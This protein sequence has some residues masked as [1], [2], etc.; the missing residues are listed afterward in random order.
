MT[1]AKLNF[2]EGMQPIR[3]LH[4]LHSMNRGGAENALMNYYRNLNRDLVQFDFLLTSFG[5]S[6]FE[7][8]I[9]DLGGIIYHIPALT[10]RN[11]L[12]YL[13]GLHSFLRSHPEY[14]IVHSHTSS[15]SVIP[16]AI[17]KMNEIPI[18]ISHSHNT[19]SEPGIK[20]RL[21]EALIPL[22]K[23]T[24]NTYFSCGE[25]AAYWLYGKEFYR[26]GKVE[27]I[28]NVINADW[29]KYNTV[30]RAK[31]RKELQCNQATIVIGQVARFNPEKNHK[32]SLE[33]LKEVIKL[34]PDT[35]L[36]L[37]GDGH[38]RTEIEDYAKEL[39]VRSHLKLVGVI[40]NVY[41]YE[42]AMDAFILP[43]LYEGLPLS[44]VEAQVSG[45]PCFTTKG[46]VSTECSVT[47]LVTYLP[48]EAGAKVWAKAIIESTSKIRRDRFE[49]IKEAG[50]DAN[51]SAH[52]LQNRYIELYKTQ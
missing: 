12:P 13:K 48:L 20:G 23:Y 39:G 33:V 9:N 37:V 8:E 29:F 6:D 50:Y 21:R 35:F 19:K 42:Q 38:L 30:T 34:H 31:I 41:D 7:D 24:A 46:S 2:N 3:I 40:P 22:L 15:K 44:I 4:I 17:A 10:I 43:S 26:K 14:K 47:D 27:V 36:L 18:R 52:K 1:P 51:T 16:L 45:L 11:P 49:E 32:F 5:K 28:K 25:Q